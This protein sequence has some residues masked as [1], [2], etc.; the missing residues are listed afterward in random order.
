M[1]IN[2][3]VLEAKVLE[4]VELIQELRGENRKL[5]SRNGELEGRIQE[6]EGL[7]ES[8]KDENTR[9]RN[10]LDEARLQADSV[11]VFEQK[12]KEIEDKVGGLL[13]KLEA[14]G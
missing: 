9:L 6:L 3:N 4:A 12:R 13:E 5:T 2:L 10:E 1:D 7:A 14:L 11:E 8:L